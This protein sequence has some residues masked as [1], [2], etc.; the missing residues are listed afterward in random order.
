MCLCRSGD[1]TSKK[2]I[3]GLATFD[4]AALLAGEQDLKK[5]AEMVNVN[6]PLKRLESI[7]TQKDTFDREGKTW[8]FYIENIREMC[9][10]HL[11]FRD[12]LKDAV[13][14]INENGRPILFLQNPRM[15]L[16][17]VL[18]PCLSEKDLYKSELFD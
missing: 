17:F 1:I 2:D 5:V 12:F 9:F 6:G 4:H 11:R 16:T 10:S 3:K 14:Y 15:K 7:P 13:P 18:A 8:Y